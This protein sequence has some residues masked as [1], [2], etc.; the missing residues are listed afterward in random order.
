[1]TWTVVKIFAS[2]HNLVLK[3]KKNALS[4]LLVNELLILKSRNMY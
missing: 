1:M 3:F 4:L 2:L